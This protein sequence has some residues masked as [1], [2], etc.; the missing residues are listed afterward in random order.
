MKIRTKLV[1]TLSVALLTGVDEQG[2]PMSEGPPLM[3]AAD[4]DMRAAA[5]VHRR[6]IEEEFQHAPVIEIEMILILR[7]GPHIGIGRASRGKAPPDARSDQARLGAEI[8]GG[9]FAEERIALHGE[10]RLALTRSK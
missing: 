6:E 7:G 2:H 8:M 4:I 3:A 10:S 5:F 9:D 1:L